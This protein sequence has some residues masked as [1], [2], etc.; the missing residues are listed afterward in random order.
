MARNGR[1]TRNRTDMR[2]T[3]PMSVGELLDEFFK[4]RALGP[5]SMEGRAVELWAEVVG[6]YVARCTED[7]YIRGGVLYVSFSSSAVR[8]EIFMRRKQLAEQLNARIGA[9]TVRSIVVR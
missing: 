5:A 7:V 4:E 9:K 2:R 3:E 1:I 8:A 6:E